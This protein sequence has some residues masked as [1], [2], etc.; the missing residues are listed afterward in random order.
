MSILVRPRGVCCTSI[1]RVFHTKCP[2]SAIPAGFLSL[3]LSSGWAERDPSC[4]FEF[5]LIV[6]AE[7]LFD[8]KLATFKTLCEASHR[9]TPVTTIA[10]GI[11][12]TR[13][14][15]REGQEK[16]L[17]RA[18]EMD[19]MMFGAEHSH[20]LNGMSILAQTLNSQDRWAEAEQLIL[21]VLEIQERKLGADDPET[22]ASTVSI[23][24]I[25]RE[26]GRLEDAP[27]GA[28]ESY[29]PP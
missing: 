8:K 22:L 10:I 1:L 9:H 7:D 24:S 21:Q 16:L 14:R 28:R 11:P 3:S 19:M 15:P 4:L 5:C 26:R 6:S 2:G 27:S 20:T 25:Y 18:V 17:L 29:W 12:L 23:A 13:I